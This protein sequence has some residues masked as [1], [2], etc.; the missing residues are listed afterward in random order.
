MNMDEI[1]Q[2]IEYCLPEIR[3]I[4]YGELEDILERKG[5]NNKLSLFP[6]MLRRQQSPKRLHSI[7]SEDFENFFEC[8]DHYL[9][10]Y[11]LQ[12]ERGEFLEYFRSWHEMFGYKNCLNKYMSD[13]PYFNCENTYKEINIELQKWIKRESFG[14]RNRIMDY[15]HFIQSVIKYRLLNICIHT[16]MNYN[17]KEVVKRGVGNRYIQGLIDECYRWQ[18]HL[19]ERYNQLR[20]VKTCKY[21]INFQ[22]KR[23]NVYVRHKRGLYHKNNIHKFIHIFCLKMFFS[24]IVRLI[25][26]YL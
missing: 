19:Y 10:G 12:C 14:Y 23:S 7:E 15:P 24:D 2:L 22:Y 6:E 26:M 8:S 11:Y 1:D 25:Y 13:S 4:T 3:K 21:C 17:L 18:M 16:K 9:E 20:V 5:N